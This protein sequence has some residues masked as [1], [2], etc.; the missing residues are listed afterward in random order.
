MG[1]AL[2]QRCPNSLALTSHRVRVTVFNVNIHH[3]N[4]IY[5]QQPTRFNSCL[6][7]LLTWS[8]MIIVIERVG[9]GFCPQCTHLL[10]VASGRINKITKLKTS[11]TGFLNTTMYSNALHSHRILIQECTTFVMW[12]S[13]SMT[14]WM[15]MIL[16]PG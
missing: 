14:S 2:S 12:W 13:R 3:C 8:D 15:E 11:Q 9:L 10:K 1:T 16:A 4:R 6:L 5:T 7:T